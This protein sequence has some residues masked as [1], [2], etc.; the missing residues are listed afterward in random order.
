MKQNNKKLIQ[1]I[2]KGELTNIEEI[3]KAKEQNNKI[4]IYVVR[5]RTDED[6]NQN[7]VKDHLISTKW[8]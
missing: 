7:K 1:Q 3:K 6:G 8:G 4:D 2:L 5:W